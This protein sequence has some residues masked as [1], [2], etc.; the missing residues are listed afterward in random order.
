MLRGKITET[1]LKQRV[2]TSKEYRN[3]QQSY[4]ECKRDAELWDAMVESYRQR[5]FMLREL[6]KFQFESQSPDYVKADYED[7]RRKFG[8]TGRR[9]TRVRK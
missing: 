9:R 6:A 2:N 1:E 4:R 8:E 5:S 7:K 3:A